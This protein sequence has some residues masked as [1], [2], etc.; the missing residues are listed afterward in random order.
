MLTRAG[1]LSAY[2]GSAAI[3]QAAG[4][5]V[6]RPMPTGQAAN[7]VTAAPTPIANGSDKPLAV[8]ARWPRQRTLPKGPEKIPP[9][10]IAKPDFEPHALA[11]MA[12]NPHGWR[13]IGWQKALMPK[14]VA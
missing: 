12:V 10:G 6:D 7:A 3:G 13:T 1:R 11:P 8:L 5:H 9:H 14:N 4:R 2:R